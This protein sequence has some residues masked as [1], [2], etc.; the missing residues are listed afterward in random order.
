M[1]EFYVFLSTIER[2]IRSDNLL[3]QSE[4]NLLILNMN[5]GT[6]FTEPAQ[7]NTVNNHLTKVTFLTN[8]MTMNIEGTR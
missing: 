3:N 5:S 2:D 7:F 4:L 8:P 1:S 6:H